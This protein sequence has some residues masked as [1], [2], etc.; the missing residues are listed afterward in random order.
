[1]KENKTAWI[2]VEEYDPYVDNHGPSYTIIAVFSTKEKADSYAKE[3]A[4]TE[5]KEYD[6]TPTIG[7]REDDIGYEV[8]GSYYFV[9]EMPIW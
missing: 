4:D 6:V 7:Y 2:V 1:M 3:L 9:K 5:A 8:L